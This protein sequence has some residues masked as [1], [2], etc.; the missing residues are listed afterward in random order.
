MEFHQQPQESQ[1]PSH[2]DSFKKSKHKDKDS[3]N[4]NDELSPKFEHIENSEKLKFMLQNKKV[5]T[6][7]TIAELSEHHRIIIFTIKWFGCPLCQD[8]LDRVEE[9]FSQ[10]LLTN[11][12][13]VI[14]HQQTQ[15]SVDYYF[16][17]T[18]SPILKNMLYTKIEKEDRELLGLKDS[19]LSQ[20][21]KTMGGN[22]KAMIYE[23]KYFQFPSDVIAPL[24]CFGVFSVEHSKI[25]KKVIYEDFSK[26]LNFG[27]FL[28]DMGVSR[29]VD[30]E[31]DYIQRITSLYKGLDLH[32]LKRVTKE[33]ISKT[34]KLEKTNTSELRTLLEDDTKRFYFKAFATNEYSLE[35][36]MFYEEIA[37][38]KKT[39]E[40]ERKFRIAE[41]IFKY[42]LD[43]KGIY[44]V[45]TSS[46]FVG[47]IK[48]KIKSQNEDNITDVMFDEVLDDV[49]YYQI[50]DTYSRFKKSKFF[51][52]MESDSD[53]V[54]YLI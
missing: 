37:L 35:S 48:E 52:A 44:Q 36:L 23:K 50:N 18:K 15:K 53:I 21:I 10:M 26:R 19:P 11:T 25:T 40:K 45:N 54:S 51:N 24:T 9:M 28:Q 16:Q 38:F 31:V 42:Y 33:V 4:S 1:I 2:R 29:V 7:Q 47:P 43:E 22:F 30:N 32:V 17:N 46:K 34:E 5:N 14:G 41:R 3:K 49:I 12:I 13:P 27:I 8:V 6:G 39:K 20:H